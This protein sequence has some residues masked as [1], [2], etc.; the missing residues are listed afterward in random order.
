MVMLV[1]F[2]H[3]PDEEEHRY[4]GDDQDE[5]DANG[6]TDDESNIRIVTGTRM[7]VVTTPNGSCTYNSRRDNPCYRRWRSVCTGGCAFMSDPCQ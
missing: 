5:R 1:G 4:S 7:S 3:A 2:S 6:Q